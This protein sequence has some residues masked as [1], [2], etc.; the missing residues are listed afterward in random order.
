MLALAARKD[1]GSNT[2]VIG[3]GDMGSSLPAAFQEAFV[4]YDAFYSADW[5]HVCDYVRAAAVV[6]DDLDSER[7]AKEMRDSI[8]QRDMQRRDRLLDTAREHRVRRLPSQ[9]E[10]CPVKALAKYVTKNWMNMQAAR[11]KELGVDYVSARAE[12]QVRDRT[13]S[14]FSVPGAWREENLEPK[15][16][17]R[18]VIGEGRWDTFRRHYLERNAGRFEQAVGVRLQ[19]A[20]NEGRLRADCLQDPQESL[21]KAA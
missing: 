5:K 3:L 7:W 10:K 9:L 14:R 19:E 17:L 4:G 18:S 12:S 2:Q 20:I 13:K 6:L 16:T 11:L 21:D 15:A 1:L 8:W